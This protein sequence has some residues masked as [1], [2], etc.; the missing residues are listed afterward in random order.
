MALHQEAYQQLI[1]SYLGVVP[2]GVYYQRLLSQATLIGRLLFKAQLLAI[3]LYGG[4]G[5]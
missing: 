1:Y 5:R 4:L 3:Y 2:T